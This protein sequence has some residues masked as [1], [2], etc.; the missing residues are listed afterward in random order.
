MP[1]LTGA[2]RM[3]RIPVPG[4]GSDFTWQALA[5]VDWQPFKNVSFVGGYRTLYQ[6]FEDNSGSK[7]FE[8]K[9]TLHGPLLGVNIKW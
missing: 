4:V 1:V 9:A 7:V 5:L 2:F 6:D 8:Y 3:C